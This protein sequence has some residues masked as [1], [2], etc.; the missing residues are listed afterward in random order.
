MCARNKR[1]EDVP[2][3]FR[4]FR[5]R[6]FPLHGHVFC[7]GPEQSRA[8]RGTRYF[9]GSCA[10]VR[11]LDGEDRRGIVSNR[12]G[13]GLVNVPYFNSGHLPNVKWSLASVV[14]ALHRICQSPAID[15][16]GGVFDQRA[17]GVMASAA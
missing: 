11:T 13:P 6:P 5:N 15:P 8:R 12:E 9:C 17:N 2:C 10:A 14:D 3:P 16:L 1:I 7:D 4:P